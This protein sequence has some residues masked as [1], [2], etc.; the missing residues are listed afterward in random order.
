MPSQS[1]E[2]RFLY[3]LLRFDLVLHLF[4]YLDLS[5]FFLDP[6][7]FS[8]KFLLPSI[9]WPNPCPN[10]LVSALNL[11]FLPS[12]CISCTFVTYVLVLE[13]NLGFFCVFVKSLGWVLLK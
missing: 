7:T 8:P 11:F 13:K 4:K 10:H 12:S 6:K 3:L 9:F 5:H 2:L 1:I